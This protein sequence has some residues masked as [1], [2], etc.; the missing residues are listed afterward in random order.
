MM[1]APHR[2]DIKNI[3]IKA[4]QGH[5]TLC[6]F[7]CGEREIDRNIEKCCNWHSRYRNR[8]FCAFL[9]NLDLVLGFYCL[10]VDA[11]NA[12]Y[13]DE[14]VLRANESYKF[15]PFI[16]INYLAVQL[17]YQSNKIGTILLM[18][19]LARCANTITNIGIYGVALHALSDRAA[20]L[21]DRYGFR[22]CGKKSKYPFMILPA[23]S[24]LDLFIK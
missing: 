11:A 1:I 22:E 20:G 14:A 21:Y 24:V 7:S 19:A 2:I 4:L 17:E 15:V 16:Y 18:N 13:L 23:Q 10:G 12:E 8:I 6:G 5:E 3:R 9:D